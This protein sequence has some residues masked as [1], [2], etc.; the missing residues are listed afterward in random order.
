MVEFG[1]E[2]IVEEEVWC[3]EVYW[4]G[5]VVWRSVLGRRC[6]VEKRDEF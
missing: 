5:G 4:G 3:R 2:N 1:V 6:G